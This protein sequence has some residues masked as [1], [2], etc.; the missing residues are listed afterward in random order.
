MGGSAALFLY[1]ADWMAARVP[2]LEAETRWHWRIFRAKIIYCV[3]LT[4]QTR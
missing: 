2:R 3:D 4:P 1:P